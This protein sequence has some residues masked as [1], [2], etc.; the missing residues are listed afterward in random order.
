M[1]DFQLWCLGMKL[2][3]ETGNPNEV[4]GTLTPRPIV[5]Q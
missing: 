1:G 3:L 2:E 5:A 4:E